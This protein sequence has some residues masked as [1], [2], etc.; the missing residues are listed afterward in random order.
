MAKSADK[1]LFRSPSSRDSKPSS[2]SANATTD[3]NEINEPNERNEVKG[4]SEFRFL[5]FEEF[6]ALNGS[7]LNRELRIPAEFD[8]IQHYNAIFTAALDE[9][10]NNQLHSAAVSAYP[11][12]RHL[13]GKSQ[14]WLMQEGEQ[15]EKSCR[16]KGCYVY[17]ACQLGYEF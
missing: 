15:L 2:F 5:C 16:S 10:I 7:R 6:Q 12:L 3:G 17:I 11:H 9:L 1:L 8:G 14:S 13:I 4:T